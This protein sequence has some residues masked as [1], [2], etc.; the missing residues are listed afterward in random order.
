MGWNG[1]MKRGRGEKEEKYVERQKI[2]DQLNS[3]AETQYSRIFIKCIHYIK[4]KLPNNG[5]N[6]VPTDHVLSSNQASSTRIGLH[7]IK[8]SKW[9]GPMGT[10]K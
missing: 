1:R 8:L 4:S 10:P 6:G 5:G 2:K 9:S 3:I 7:L